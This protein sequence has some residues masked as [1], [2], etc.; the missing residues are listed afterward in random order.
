MATWWHIYGAVVPDLGWVQITLGSTQYGPDDVGA[1][2]TVLRQTRIPF[3]GNE[4][5]W[6]GAFDHE[7]SDVEKDSFTPEGYGDDD[8]Y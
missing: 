6:L 3:E 1:R 2:G 8:D 4:L 5:S 7:P